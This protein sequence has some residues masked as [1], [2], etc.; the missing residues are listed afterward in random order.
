MLGM[1]ARRAKRT[2][3][4]S[5]R[6]SRRSGNAN[7]PIHLQTDW[8]YIACSKREQKGAMHASRDPGDVTCDRCKSAS[9]HLFPKYSH[10]TPAKLR[11]R[12]YAYWRSQPALDSGHFDN[13][14][15]DDGT[16]RVWV[17]RQSLADYDG[18]RAAWKSEQMTIE[19][20]LKGRWTKVVAPNRPAL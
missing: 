12:G 9:P 15:Y 7:P 14:V 17:S 3:R 20:L 1:A 2:S 16:Y 6:S 4:K 10:E 11:G 13:L 5:G 19:Q 18:D 8:R